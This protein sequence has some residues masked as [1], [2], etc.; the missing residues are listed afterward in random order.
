MQTRIGTAQQ[1][2]D[3]TATV[4]KAGVSFTN[5]LLSILEGKYT[6]Q[7][8]E[9]AQLYFGCHRDH[10]LNG[11]RWPYE[12]AWRNKILPSHPRGDDRQTIAQSEVDESLRPVVE[13]IILFIERA[14]AA[15][16]VHWK[17]GNYPNRIATFHPDTVVLY[18]GIIGH[19]KDWQSTATPNSESYGWHEDFGDEPSVEERPEYQEYLG[20]QELDGDSANL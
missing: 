15:G 3:G 8:L 5:I 4:F 14:D 1:F 16:L 12:A 11:D 13:A 2:I 6:I 20:K 19:A 7:D 18:Q 17:S 10:V 9:G